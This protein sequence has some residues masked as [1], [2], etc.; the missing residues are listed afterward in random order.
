MILF[1]ILFCLVIA[2][3]VWLKLL[4][5]WLVPTYTVMS[6]FTF[7]VYG[8]DKY[9]AKKDKVRVPEST[10][11]I[12]DVLGGWLGAVFEQAFFRHKTLK[13]SFR[14]WFLLTISVNV[15]CVAVLALLPVLTNLSR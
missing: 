13:Q 7:I 3:L 2:G 6:V 10:L 15:L 12:Y 1:V 9:K 11:H 5:F 14:K 8:I 4:P